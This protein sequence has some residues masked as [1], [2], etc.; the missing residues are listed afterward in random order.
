MSSISPEL[1]TIMGIEEEEEIKKQ[2]L[3]LLGHVQAL[4]S[5]WGEGFSLGGTGAERLRNSHCLET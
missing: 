4:S 1:Y 5:G 3:L 2:E